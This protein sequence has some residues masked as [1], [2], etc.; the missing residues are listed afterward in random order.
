MLPSTPSNTPSQHRRL[1]SPPASKR[2]PT[3]PSATSPPA[4]RNLPATPPSGH[5]KLPSPTETRKSVTPPSTQ[6]KAPS[7]PVLRREGTPHS[8]VGSYPFKAPSPPASP[9]VQRWT[10]ENSSEEI[11]PLPSPAVSRGF[12]NARSV[13]CPASP[14]L[15][16]AQP[17]LQPQPPKAW[18]STS[19]RVLPRPWGESARGRLPMSV[20][21]PRPFVRRCH[22]DHRPSLT[23]PP[24][25][26]AV[27]VA[28]SCGS[29]P[30]IN[31]QGLEDGPTREEEHWASQLDLRAANRSASH[32]DLCIVGQA[33]QRE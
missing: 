31:T 16:E 6:W 7:P 14:N 1:P 3:P 9:R 8:S 24:Q 5:R 20:R 33:L 13:F 11:V 28:H 10:R 21:G 18:A 2:Q 25:T 30:S 27:S 32:P 15:F 19:G 22:S 4:N 12:N 29:E 23:L 17:C 26:P